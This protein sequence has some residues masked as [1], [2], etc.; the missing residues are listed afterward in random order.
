MNRTGG[1]SPGH[2]GHSFTIMKLA[3]NMQQPC[4]CE[5]SLTGKSESN[6]TVAVTD[7]SSI[8]WHI[9]W[10]PISCTWCIK[11]KQ[12]CYGRSKGQEKHTTEIFTSFFKAYKWINLQKC[13]FSFHLLLWLVYI[14]SFPQHNY[15]DQAMQLIL[16]SFKLMAPFLQWPINT[17]RNWTNCLMWWNSSSIC[18]T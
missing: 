1:N 8:M 18:F 3:L 14:S 13:L 12:F 7:N 10:M 9:Q 11:V 5:Q 16:I 4:K 17:L 15:E 6:F 2:N